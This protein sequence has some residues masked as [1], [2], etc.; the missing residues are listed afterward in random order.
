MDIVDHVGNYEPSE[1]YDLDYFLYYIDQ[2]QPIKEQLGEFLDDIE[3]PIADIKL[4]DIVFVEYIEGYYEK[5]RVIGFGGDE[6]VNGHYVLDV[7]YVD[8]W[9]SGPDNINNYIFGKARVLKE[10]IEYE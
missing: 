9:G 2:Q 10:E 7:P 8:K 5:R 6:Y 3:T 1:G 4:G